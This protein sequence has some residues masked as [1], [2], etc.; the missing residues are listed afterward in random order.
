MKLV[1]SGRFESGGF[2]GL[3]AVF[4]HPFHTDLFL[5]LCNKEKMQRPETTFIPFF[6][7]T[8]KPPTSIHVHAGPRNWWS[9]HIERFLAY[10]KKAGPLASERPECSAPR[11]LSSINRWG[12]TDTY[13]YQQAQQAIDLF[14]SELD[15]WH[16]TSHDGAL[17]GPHFRL[18]VSRATNEPPPATSADLPPVTAHTGSATLI[19]KARRVLRVR[20]Y[21]MRTEEAYLHWI[22]RFIASCAKGEGNPVQF[23]EGQVRT[24]LEGLAVE[25]CVSASTQNQ[26]FSG[27]LLRIGI[28]FLPPGTIS[29]AWTRER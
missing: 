5:F 8:F 22:G 3:R 26:A 29:S 15:H 27:I 12:N 14:I 13:G 6:H 21:A 20:H 18:K 25:R 19:E 28:C 10:C 16:W 4:L 11:F 9:I 24:F 1:R 23:G 2:F 7:S 17:Y